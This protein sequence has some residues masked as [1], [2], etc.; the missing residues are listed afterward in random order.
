MSLTQLK[1]LRSISHPHGTAY[2]FVATYLPKADPAVPV[3][4]P[5]RPITVK[6]P[7]PGDPS[8][9]AFTR[10]YYRTLDTLQRG[11]VWVR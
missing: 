1:H 7:L 5:R 3:K 11:A 8:I 9:P 6:F 2:Y 4:G 10:E